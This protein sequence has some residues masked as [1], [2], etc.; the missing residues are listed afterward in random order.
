MESAPIPTSEAS[1][2]TEAS[3]PMRNATVTT[4]APTG[5]IGILAGCSS[6]IEPI[7]ALAYRRRA[8]EGQEFIQIHP[9][10]EKLAQY[11]L[12]LLDFMEKNPL[13][14]VFT[15]STIK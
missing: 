7:Y 6:G 3:V 4:V 1:A 8:L 5:S 2:P 10:L 15:R 11:E 12:A 13:K 9:L 14:T